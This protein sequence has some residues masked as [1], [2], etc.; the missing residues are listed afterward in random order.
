MKKIKMQLITKIII[1]S[2]LILISTILFIL[3]FKESKNYKTTEKETKLYNYNLSS[4]IK[5]NVKLFDNSIYDENILPQD[6]V[7]I[8]SVV[9]DIELSFTN[10]FFGSERAK[11]LGKYNITATVKGNISEQ[12]ESKVL[13]SKSFILKN[14][15]KFAT[16]SSKEQIIENLILDYDWFNN[17]SKEIYESTKILTANVIELV[18]NI[19]YN[20]ETKYGMVKES[21]NPTII[22]PIGSNYFSTISSNLNEKTGDIKTIDK[23]IVDPNFAMIALCRIIIAILLLGIVI[24][25]IFTINPSEYDMYLKK[26]DKIFKNYSKLLVGIN[27]SNNLDC[28]NIFYVKSFEDLIKISDEIEKP[29]FYNFSENIVDM[30]KFYII[31]ENTSYIYY[32]E[33]SPAIISSNN[34]EN[35]KSIE[36][37]SN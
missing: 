9:D 14:D 25:F 11:I 19:E 36:F 34:L 26:I 1:S 32:V 17:L 10:K 8:S 4:D 3:Q 31:N 21:I 2:V 16:L 18:M 5:Y 20:V 33:H 28:D 15:T 23:L 27:N 29:I 12:N 22:I 30:N 7:Y 35:S 13:W 37:L 6:R 24:L